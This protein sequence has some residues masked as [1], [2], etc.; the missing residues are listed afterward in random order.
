MRVVEDWMAIQGPRSSCGETDPRCGRC[1]GDAHPRSAAR[2]R[3]RV[4]LA[5]IEDERTCTRQQLATGSYIAERH[6][7][8]VRLPR[9]RR[10]YL[11]RMVRLVTGFCAI[12]GSLVPALSQPLR[13]SC[14]VDRGLT[15]PVCAT[16]EAAHM[17]ARTTLLPD[18]RR[19]G[20]GDD[21]AWR[22]RLRLLL[23]VRGRLLLMG[24]G[25]LLLRSLQLLH[26]LLLLLRRSSRP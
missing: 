9:F 3:A 20:R 14:T 10:R 15:G 7:P 25:R 26:G 24:C 2:A 8:R 16:R 11:S 5:G 21:S 18:L 12:F 1:A 22:A 23:L 13:F 17:R 6:A 4:A 19:R